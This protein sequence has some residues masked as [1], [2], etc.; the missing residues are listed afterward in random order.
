[1]ATVKDGITTVTTAGTRV[2]LAPSEAVSVVY[3]QGNSANTNPV[4][5]GGTTVVAAVATRRGVSLAAG[6]TQEIVTDDI[7]DIW[8]DAVTSGEKVNFAYVSEA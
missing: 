8:V 2:Q 4:V 3:V 6:V 7:G 5:V 1:M